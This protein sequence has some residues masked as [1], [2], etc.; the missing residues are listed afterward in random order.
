MASASPLDSCRPGMQRMFLRMSSSA[1]QISVHPWTT[2]IIGNMIGIFVKTTTR[3]ILDW[4]GFGFRISNFHWRN[5]S[6]GTGQNLFISST[7]PDYIPGNLCA[8]MLN[9]TRPN[10]SQD[11]L[12]L[13]HSCWVVFWG[14]C[15][16]FSRHQLCGDLGANLFQEVNLRPGS[17]TLMQVCSNCS[18]FVWSGCQKDV[19]SVQECQEIPTAK[20]C[21]PGS[22]QCSA[23]NS[24]NYRP[25]THDGEFVGNVVLQQFVGEVITCSFS[26]WCNWVP[27]SEL[28][29][30]WRYCSNGL[31]CWCCW[32]GGREVKP[33]EVFEV[34]DVKE[35][36]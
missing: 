19:P 21:A 34:Q 16:R 1:T 11:G 3:Y 4:L 7:Y 30:V 24:T 35:I 13:A 2:F 29:F 9:I 26:M 31:Y 23:T 18:T 33:G 32:R 8:K 10:D 12:Q 15:R 20:V 25:M 28:L 17:N 5:I 22:A 14:L 27:W 6:M 36:F